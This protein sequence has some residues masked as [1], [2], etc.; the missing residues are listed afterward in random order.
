MVQ[1]APRLG[2][3]HLLLGLHDDDLLLGRRGRL[4]DDHHPLR[5]RAAPAG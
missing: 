1:R 2:H 3:D 5:G 4:L